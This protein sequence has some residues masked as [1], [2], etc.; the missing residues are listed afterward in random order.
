MSQIAEQR[1]F[2]ARA[3]TCTCLV[4]HPQGKEY[5]RVF[6]EWVRTGKSSMVMTAQLFG[7]C[8]AK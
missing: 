5:Q 2:V 3:G 7:D 8:P 1:D 6:R 4:Y